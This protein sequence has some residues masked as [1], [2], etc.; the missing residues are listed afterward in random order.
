[1]S[2]KFKISSSHKPQSGLKMR[3]TELGCLR[4]AVEESNV[5]TFTESLTRKVSKSSEVMF[6][7]E[8]KVVFC[9]PVSRRTTKSFTTAV[10]KI[11]HGRLR[12]SYVMQPPSGFCTCRESLTPDE[13]ATLWYGSRRSKSLKRFSFHRLQYTGNSTSKT[14]PHSQLNPPTIL[15]CWLTSSPLFY[16]EFI[17]SIERDIA[18]RWDCEK[19]MKRGYMKDNCK[20]TGFELIKTANARTTEDPRCCNI[21]STSFSLSPKCRS[22]YNFPRFV[23][24][25]S[26]YMRLDDSALKNNEA[27]K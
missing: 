10:A 26:S 12:G 18:G 11:Y 15:R 20:T 21:T 6:T 9:C 14:T 25:T 7:A 2:Y 17:F 27:V 1:M 24:E 23:Q 13:L 22:S 4:V 5:T 3:H 16:T 8:L 19:F